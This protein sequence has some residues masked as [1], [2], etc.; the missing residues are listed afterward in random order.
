[1]SIDVTQL[2]NWSK[3]TRYSDQVLCAHK[4]KRFSFCMVRKLQV[5]KRDGVKQV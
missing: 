5:V 4:L 2:L 3:D 1:M